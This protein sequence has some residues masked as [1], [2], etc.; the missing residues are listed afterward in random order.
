MSAWFEQVPDPDSPAAGSLIVRRRYGLIQASAGR[1]DF[2]QVRPWPKMISGL[3]VWLADG[4]YHRRQACDQVRIWYNQPWQHSNYLTLAYSLSALG[5]TL[6]TL[7]AG[8]TTLDRIA[9]IKQSDAILCQA[10]SRRVTDRV[11]RYFGYQRHLTDRRR[12]HYIRRF[13]GEY[14]GSGREQTGHASIQSAALP[15]AS[16]ETT[17][18]GRHRVS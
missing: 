13:Y 17:D 1:L 4:V 2:V 6:A 3:E 8:L 14:P 15:L 5:T 7:R 11:M 9:R 16:L 18:G 10:S 12:R